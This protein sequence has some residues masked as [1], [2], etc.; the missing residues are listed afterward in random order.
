MG[1]KVLLRVSSLWELLDLLICSFVNSDKPRMRFFFFPRVFFASDYLFLRRG[2]GSS[3]VS[4]SLLIWPNETWSNWRN[5]CLPLR[6]LELPLNLLLL[7]E[8]SL[9]WLPPP[10]ISL[11]PFFRSW[12]L[13]QTLLEADFIIL[14]GVRWLPDAEFPLCFDFEL[15]L[16]KSL[17]LLANGDVAY[18][19]VRAWEENASFS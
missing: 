1:L 16:I 14:I 5:C 7:S 4:L 13:L 17:A 3:F 19:P 8:P 12:A 15:D 6:K 11:L 10:D 2:G 18:I 9:G